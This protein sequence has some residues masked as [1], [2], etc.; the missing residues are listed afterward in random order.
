VSEPV[1]IFANI[2]TFRQGRGHLPWQQSEAN[3]RV[4]LDAKFAIVGMMD[5][6]DLAKLVVASVNEGAAEAR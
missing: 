1:V 4:L 6:A 2:E 3:P 5:T